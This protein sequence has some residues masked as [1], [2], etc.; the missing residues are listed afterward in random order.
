LQEEKKLTIQGFERQGG[1]LEAVRTRQREL[2]V[3]SDAVLSF[4]A[5]TE[6]GCGQETIAVSFDSEGGVSN[7]GPVA[8]MDCGG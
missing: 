4:D 7:V 3:C 6:G 1:F 8:V 2:L 5:T